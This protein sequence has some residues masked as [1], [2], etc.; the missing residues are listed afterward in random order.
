MKKIIAAMIGL[1]MAG[2]SH[3]QQN[4]QT[5]LNEPSVTEQAKL[6]TKNNYPLNF[7]TYD[8]LRMSL[9]TD[10]LLK[11]SKLAC[12]S[13]ATRFL[14]VGTDGTLSD[15][16]GAACDSNKILFGDNK[17]KVL[18]I[19]EQAS[20][21]SEISQGYPS[22]LYGIGANPQGKIAWVPPCNNSWNPASSQ[23]GY[24]IFQIQRTNG[25][26][27]VLNMGIN[28]LGDG[29]IS[30]EAVTPPGSQ[31][32]R[33]NPSCNNDV[34]ICQGGGFTKIYYSANVGG[35]LGVENK[36]YIGP[37]S[38]TSG[39]TQFAM[40]LDALAT[41]AILITDPSLSTTN[42]TVFEVT[43]KGEMTVGADLQAV[44]GTM[45]TI[46]QPQWNSRAISLVD[47]SSVPQAE[48]FN[49]WGDGTTEIN[50]GGN[51]AFSIKNR[52]NGNTETFAIQAD[53]H[54]Q[55]KAG[56]VKAFSVFN[57]ANSNKE[58]FTINSD[59]YTEIK[60]Y[61]PAGMPAPY[62]SGNRAMTIRDVTNNKD[63]FVVNANG[64][65]YAREVEISLVA[66]F[67]D[68]VF[69]K[70]YDL[71]PI[72]EVDNYIKAHKRLPGFE[73]AAH[74]EKNGINVNELFIKQQEKIEELTLYIIQL[75]KRLQ[76]IETK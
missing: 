70:N 29:I 51:K 52:Y 76:A 22:K 25:G 23:V 5:T 74:Y 10:G 75:E 36:L 66:N 20:T 9:G 12:G 21:S 50:A 64:K 34:E 68:Y 65:T 8:S 13:P 43:K 30:V 53:G 38:S 17:W 63:I 26:S 41:K 55:I 69:E 71:K 33:L 42:K 56:N 28:W 32:L 39:S 73:N 19:R 45:L 6:G 62:S 24:D 47:N 14:K 40:N 61:S 31:K 27:S 2:M 67:P 15:W 72:A 4:W 60:I 1:A 58:T 59:G 54:T 7:Y 16:K 49:I 11:M 3:A 57:V 18:A 46:G 37:G 48:V 35:S 44:A